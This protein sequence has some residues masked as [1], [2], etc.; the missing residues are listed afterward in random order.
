VV[1]GRLYA[2]GGQLRHD[3]TPVDL[4]VVH[5]YDAGRDTWAAVA[6]LPS[7]RSH[8]EASTF[9]QHD[10][11]VIVGGRNNTRWRPLNRA[12]LANVTAYD[13]ATDTWTE[14]PA[15]P[16]GLQ[17]TCARVIDG[18]LIVTNGSVME[19]VRGQPRTFLAD[20]P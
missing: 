10:R 20:F 19:G 17:A 15:L 14:L 2:I 8:V 16:I 7:P 5:V 3:T 4:D 6:R 13:P 12:G 18:R 9:V 11:I 1:R